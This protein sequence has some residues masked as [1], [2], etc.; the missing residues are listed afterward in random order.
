MQSLKSEANTVLGQCFKW[1]NIW[2]GVLISRYIA[3]TMCVTQCGI[4]V[5]GRWNAIA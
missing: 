4:P 2:L 3:Q 1:E 5:K